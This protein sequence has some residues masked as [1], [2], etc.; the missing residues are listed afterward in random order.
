[1]KGFKKVYNGKSE[2]SNI[3]FLGKQTVNQ[4][5]VMGANLVRL[6]RENVK[7][8]IKALAKQRDQWRIEA[9]AKLKACHFWQFKKKRQIRDDIMSYAGAGGMC[10]LIIMQLDEIKPSM[11]KISKGK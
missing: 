4:A 7:D 5:C 8:D 11:P 6:F 2:V 1:P 9:E 3:Q 10:S